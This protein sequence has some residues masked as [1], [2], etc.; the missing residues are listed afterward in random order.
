MS[1]SFFEI[2]EAV[3]VQ[4]TGAVRLL[5]TSP[6]RLPVLECSPDSLFRFR[7]SPTLSE[8]KKQGLPQ[9]HSKLNR[10]HALSR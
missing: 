1:P 7:L 10:R 9:L 6:P 8:S 3:T 2:F 5:Q 4:S